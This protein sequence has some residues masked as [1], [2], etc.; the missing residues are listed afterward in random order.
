MSLSKQASWTNVACTSNWRILAS[1]LPNGCSPS[2]PSSRQDPRKKNRRFGFDDLKNINKYLMTLRDAW[3]D[4]C[5]SSRKRTTGTPDELEITSTNTH[6]RYWIRACAFAQSWP[7]SWPA[8]APSITLRFGITFTKCPASFPTTFVNSDATSS[9]LLYRP[10]L[11][12]WLQYSLKAEARAE[13]GVICWSWSNFP[14]RNKAP[15]AEVKLPIWLANAVLP[16]PEGPTINP[17][18]LCPEIERL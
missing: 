16:I 7:S 12:I 15:S 10:S 13:K 14:F 17:H 2:K 9:R 18:S 4:H 8:P 1:I 6:S 5:K 11:N 3:S